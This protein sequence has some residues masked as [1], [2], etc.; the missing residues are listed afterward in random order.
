MCHH[1]RA[2]LLLG[3]DRRSR[4]P[5]ALGDQTMRHLLTQA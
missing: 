2:R 3:V 4:L 5:Q 1:P